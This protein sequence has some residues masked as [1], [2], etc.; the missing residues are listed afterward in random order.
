[1]SS[2]EQTSSSAL[3]STL[4]F[5]ELRT[6]ESNSFVCFVSP[7][8]VC[9]DQYGTLYTQLVFQFLIIFAIIVATSLSLQILPILSLLITLKKQ[10]LKKNL[11]SN[12][13]KKKME[14]QRDPLGLFHCIRK[15]HVISSE[16]KCDLTYTCMY[17][18]RN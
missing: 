17:T 12:N 4:K 18:C 9:Y 5:I 13:L 7:I 8:A 11:S 16:W 15:L 1:M 14:G 6:E 3:S 10:I 2:V